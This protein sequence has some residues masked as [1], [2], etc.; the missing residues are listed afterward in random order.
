[1]GQKDKEPHLISFQAQI[2]RITQYIGHVPCV[3]KGAI[4][5][6]VPPANPTDMAP[7][8]VHEWRV[9]IGL[10]ITASVMQAM[11]CDPTRRAV[12]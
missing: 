4:K 12:L 11:D 6:F 7:K 1:M 9:W 8:K 3:I 2:I 10:L 5:F